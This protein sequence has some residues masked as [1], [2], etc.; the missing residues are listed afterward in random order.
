MITKYPVY[1]MGS[2]DLGWLQSRFHFSFADYFNRNNM[3]FG[4][5]RVINDDYVQPKTGFETHPHKNMEIVSYV[6]DGKLTHKDSMGNEKTLSRGNFQYM[7]AGTGV[8]HSEMN[9][10]SDSVTR[11]LQIWIFPDE[12]GLT[13]NYGDFIY[14]DAKRKNVFFHAV[15]SVKG[16]APIKIH[17]DV[18]IYVAELEKGKELDFEVAANRQAY[19]VQAEGISDINGTT[20]DPRDGLTTVEESLKIKAIEDS[21]F[22]IIEMA[23][24]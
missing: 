23:K 18:N 21:H 3:N 24:V 19:L 15:S 10:Q 20:L 12:Q 22:L 11:L 14:D 8:F 17:Q 16:D 5:L 9:N 2:S 4:V 13:P 6:L 1:N 7:S